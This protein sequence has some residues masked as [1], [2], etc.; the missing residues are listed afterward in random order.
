MSNILKGLTE[1]NYRNY[2]TNRTGFSRGP[3]D[4]ER[5]D[6][7]VQQP[8]QQQWALKI[9]GKVWSKDGNA[10]TFNSKEQALKARQSLLAKRPE[11]DVGLVTRGGVAE[12]QL[13]ELSP[14][15]LASY[16][17]KAGIAATDA[18]KAGDY[19]LGNKRFSGIVRATKKEFDNDTKQVKE[20]EEEHHHQHQ[21]HHHVQD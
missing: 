11:L 7:D 2:D 9:N 5:H 19:K 13:D 20:D 4:D 12:Q 10:V 6:L 15:T 8:S 16:K 3:R 17:K 14:E 21:H 1:S 18:D